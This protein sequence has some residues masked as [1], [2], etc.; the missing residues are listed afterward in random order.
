MSLY[1]FG[2]FQTIERHLKHLS[3]AVSIE[4]MS[5]LTERMEYS[6]EH[7]IQFRG[8]LYESRIALSTG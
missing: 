3:V 4:D 2:D 5:V 7:G 1:T 8:R 6:S